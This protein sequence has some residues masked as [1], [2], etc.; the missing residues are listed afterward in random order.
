MISLA[1]L[2]DAI[3]GNVQEKAIKA[4]GASNNEVVGHSIMQLSFTVYYCPVSSSILVPIYSSPAKVII[5]VKV[6]VFRFSTP[7]PSVAVTF[8]SAH[9]SAAS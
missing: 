8:W 6:I 9:C 1:L 7:I 2:A 3:I 4:H 5:V